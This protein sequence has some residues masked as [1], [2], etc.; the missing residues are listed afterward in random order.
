MSTAIAVLCA[1]EHP[2]EFAATWDR[3]MDELAHYRNEVRPAVAALVE[4]V[5]ALIL[6]STGTHP[7]DITACDCGKPLCRI[8]TALADLTAALG[9][10]GQ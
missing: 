1:H 8:L 3:L 6:K 4:A 10:E 5:E 9:G 2:A 7:D